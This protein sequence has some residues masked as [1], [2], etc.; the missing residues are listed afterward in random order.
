MIH[1]R[2]D[3]QLPIPRFS[4]PLPRPLNINPKSAFNDLDVL[5]LRMVD[6]QERFLSGKGDEAR[7]AQVERDLKGEGKGVVGLVCR[8]EEGGN[9]AVEAG[10][11]D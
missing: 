6:L 7:V 4:D 11:R 3:Q 10:L 5:F 8:E 1:P 2:S 9:R